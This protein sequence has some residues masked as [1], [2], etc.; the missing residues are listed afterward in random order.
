MHR[1]TYRFALASFLAASAWLLASESRANG[2]FP[3][4]DQLLID[5]LDPRHI[6]VRTTFGFVESLDGGKNW[7][8]TCE[9]IIGRIANQDPP[10][11]VSGDGSVVVAVPFEGVSV[12][13]DHGCSWT[14]APEPLAGQ[15]AV[16][17]TLE[18]N[19]PA[20]LL[21]LTSTND[22][23]PDAGPNAPPEFLNLVVE[24]KDNAVSWALRGAPLARDFI[25][26]TIEI[27]AA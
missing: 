23:P 9:E 15:L 16:D 5:P 12:T 4:A 11:A 22:T 3:A 8:W 25:A 7:A 13:H 2:R 24:T 17:V 26:A 19:D 18:P 20:A 1:R 10:F 21:V 6:V 14:R 27:A